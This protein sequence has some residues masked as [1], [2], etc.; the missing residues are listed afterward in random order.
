MKLEDLIRQ[1]SESTENVVSVA[2]AADLEVLEAV[3]MAIE[4]EMASFRLYDDE[5]KLKAL[6]NEQ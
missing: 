5:P 4:L 2:A 3:S 1:A 6:I